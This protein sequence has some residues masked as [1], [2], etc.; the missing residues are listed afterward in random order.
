MIQPLPPEL[1]QLV[2]ALFVVPLKLSTKHLHNNHTEQ[3]NKTLGI[4][5]P[6]DN[7]HF[8]LAAHNQFSHRFY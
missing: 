2:N 5:K 4:P 7:T 1:A 3:P 6:Y 8:L